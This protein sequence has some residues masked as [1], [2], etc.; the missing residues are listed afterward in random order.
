MEHGTWNMEHGTW[1]MEHSGTSRNI[2]EHPGTFRNIPEHRII[3][4]I[5]R[6]IDKMKFKKI[7]SNKNK[8]VSARKIEKNKNIKKGKKNSKEK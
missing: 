8:L 5:M 3:I 4:I 2:P 1:N 7:K 6:K